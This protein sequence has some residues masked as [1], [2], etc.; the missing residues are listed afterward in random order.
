VDLEYEVVDVFTDTAFTG[1]PLAVV[2]PALLS[3]AVVAEGGAAV[4]CRVSGSVVPV[5][6]GRI[7]L[8]GPGSRP[9]V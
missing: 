2:R 8:P 7:C 1:N 5:T 6:A 3:C 9:G 4:S